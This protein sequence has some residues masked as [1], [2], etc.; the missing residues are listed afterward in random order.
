MLDI[1]RKY[2][3]AERTGNWELHLQ[4]IQEMPPYLAASGHNL[5]V[6]SARLFLQ[7]MSNLKTQ[8][9]NVQQ[10]FE[11][12]FHVV[13][14]SDRLWAG[15]SSDLIIEQ[16][17]MRSL[18][19]CGGLKRGR[20]MTEQQRLLWLLS[21][22]ACAEINQA[23][24]EITRVNFNT[25]EQNQDMTKARQSRD[26]KDTLS[27]LRYLQKRNPFS[28]DPTL[29]NIATGFHAHPTVTVDTA[30]AVGAKILASMDGKTPAEYTFKRKDQAVTIG[31]K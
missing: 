4:T 8:H 17:L 5:Y 10:Y 23:M 13:R 22:P 11:E 12:G 24:Q 26:W 3:R 21:M 18:K 28:S 27:V 30:H 9:P 2:I 1:L 14:R 20:G 15:L 7:Q 31:I 6:K 25:G 29:R 19:T 16:V